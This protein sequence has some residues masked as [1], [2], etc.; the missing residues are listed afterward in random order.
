MTEGQNKTGVFYVK[1]IIGLLVLLALSAVFLFSA[2]SKLDTIEPFEWTFLD[3]GAPGMVSASVI[4]HLFIGLEFAIGLFLLAHIYLKSVTYPLTIA[5]LVLLTGYLLLLIAQQGNNGNCGCF[6]DWIYMKPLAAVWKNLVMIAAVVLL[7]FIYPVK[8]YAGQEWIAA[9]LGMAALVLPFVLSPLDLDNDP[10][11]INRPIDLHALYEGNK[12]PHI[13]LRKG[14]HIVAFMSLTC[15]HC[16][17]AAYLLHVLKKKHND[18]PVYLVLNGHPDQL[19]PFFDETHASNVPYLFYRDADEFKEMAGEYVPA[20][21]WI[22]NG[23]VEKQSNY[24]QL[25]APKMK[26]WAKN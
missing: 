26:E 12:Q 9:C 18:L 19:K 10:K 15:P 16:K 23:M 5:I 22:N 17:K 1:R 20:I 4:A 11:S 14:K 24:L 3:L 25:D 21:Y 6:G 7:M 8:P 13:D 2:Y